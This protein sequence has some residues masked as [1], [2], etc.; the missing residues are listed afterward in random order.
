MAAASAFTLV[1]MQMATV[2]TP[3]RLSVTVVDPAE[4]VTVTSSTLLV[5]PVI[6]L[7]STE[8][9]ERRNFVTSVRS[10]GGDGNSDTDIMGFQLF[11]Y[12][13]TLTGRIEE[14]DMDIDD[15]VFRIGVRISAVVNEERKRNPDDDHMTDEADFAIDAIQEA[16]RDALTSAT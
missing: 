12:W 10:F 2:W 11:V 5:R 6:T 3:M 16:I 8:A 15:F 13:C 7:D 14:D 9:I 4:S 1:G